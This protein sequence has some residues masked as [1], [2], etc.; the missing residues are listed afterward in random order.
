MHADTGL[1]IRDLMLYR[2]K[3]GSRWSA[4]RGI[5]QLEEEGI[6][7]GVGGKHQSSQSVAR[8]SQEARRRFTLAILAARKARYPKALN[9][10]R[11][12]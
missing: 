4:P 7:R 6:V 5:P 2:T 12:A 1:S 11:S 8:T 10:G 9:G 3:N